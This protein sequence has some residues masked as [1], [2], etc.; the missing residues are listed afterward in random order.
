MDEDKM[1]EIAGTYPPNYD[2]T[3]H[4]TKTCILWQSET[5][6]SKDWTQVTL[7]NKAV[8]ACYPFTHQHELLFTFQPKFQISFVDI[9]QVQ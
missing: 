1:M 2:V 6:P 4:H 9:S 7:Q 8:C 5:Q 3:S